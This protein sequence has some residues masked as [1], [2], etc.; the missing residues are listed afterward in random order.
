MVWAAI[1]AHC[2]A[3]H[4][5]L[6]AAA[7]LEKKKKRKAYQSFWGASYMRKAGTSLA[8]RRGGAGSLFETDFF[9]SFGRGVLRKDNTTIIMVNTSFLPH[10]RLAPSGFEGPV[11]GNSDKSRSGRA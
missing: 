2:G 5:I 7:L 4:Q 6:D 9:G 11:S 10:A 8:V 3:V 1:D